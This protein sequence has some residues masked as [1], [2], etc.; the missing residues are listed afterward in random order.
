[1]DELVSDCSLATASPVSTPLPERSSKSTISCQ[2]VRM[3]LHISSIQPYPTAWHVELLAAPADPTYFLDS[4]VLSPPP[5]PRT[6]TGH[7]LFLECPVPN[8]IA[9][10]SG[11]HWNAPFPWPFH[12]RHSFLPP[13]LNALAVGLRPFAAYS[14]RQWQLQAGPHPRPRLPQG[15]CVFLLG[16][17][18]KLSP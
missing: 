4:T 7:H 11:M 2:K 14:P 17:F 10:P 6:H 5:A 12:C 8:Q 1:M 16:P 3:L 9:R 15:F 13:A 18:L